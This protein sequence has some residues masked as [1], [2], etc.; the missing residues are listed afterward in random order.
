MY[1]LLQDP[2]QG[3]PEGYGASLLQSVLALAAVCVLAWVVLRMFSRRGFGVGPTGGRVRV[4]ERIPLDA[5]RMLYVVKVGERLLLLGS[6]D[7]A[8]PALI[9]EIDPATMPPVPDAKPVG[10]A[11]RDV[12]ARVRGRPAAAVVKGDEE[13]EAKASDDAK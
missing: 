10:E 3:L 9:T 8:S 7:G 5:R 11:F 13:E 6:G 12:L 2:P 4:V 1:A